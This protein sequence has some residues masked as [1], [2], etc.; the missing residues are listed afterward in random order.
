[1]SLGLS[2][3]DHTCGSPFTSK[4]EP[5]SED[6]VTNMDYTYDNFVKEEI[7]DIDD[8]DEND[9]GDDNLNDDDNHN[10]EEKPTIIQQPQLLKTTP[11]TVVI[12]PKQTNGPI[13][14]SK[15]LSKPVF[16]PITLSNVKT[17]KVRKKLLIVLNY[18][19][20]L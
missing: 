5:K 15:H 1:M 13:T 8:D 17:I 6:S 2:S 14:I 4:I 10:V 19:S 12:S 18:Y 3:V 9:N 11:R 20:I 16:I 7:I